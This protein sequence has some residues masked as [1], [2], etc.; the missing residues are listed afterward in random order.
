M[1]HVFRPKSTCVSLHSIT[2]RNF[3]QDITQHCNE[4]IQRIIIH[5]V[6]QARRRETSVPF[7]LFFTPSHLLFPLSHLPS[8]VS[9]LPSSLPALEH[10]ASWSPQERAQLTS[11]RLQSST[12]SPTQPRPT[13]HLTSTPN[14]PRT[15]DSRARVR[16]RTTLGDRMCLLPRW[17]RG[18]RSQR[19]GMRWFLA[20]DCRGRNADQVL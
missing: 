8:P 18:W 5:H 19:G 10:S 1:P 16:T 7:L 20:S 3:P 6:R 17:R 2:S 4:Y 9:L 15:V 11:P 13:T 12:F 14:P